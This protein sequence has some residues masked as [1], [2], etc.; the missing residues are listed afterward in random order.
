MELEIKLLIVQLVQQSPQTA[1]I[2]A[3]SSSIKA[4]LDALED[5]LSNSCVE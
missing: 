2:E 1:L 3:K 5:K 4:L